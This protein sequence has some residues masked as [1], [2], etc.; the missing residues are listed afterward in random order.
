MGTRKSGG[1]A[2]EEK[3]ISS[4]ADFNHFTNL[5]NCY[6][7]DVGWNAF[8]SRSV[9]TLNH[10]IVGEPGLDGAILKCYLCVGIR[11]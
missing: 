1:V 2:A 6:N 10:V 8:N 11:I 3:E 7:S 5:G 4:T 9:Y